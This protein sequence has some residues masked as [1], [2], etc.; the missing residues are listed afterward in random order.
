MTSFLDTLRRPTWLLPEAAHQASPL[1]SPDA[2][3]EVHL[4]G[5]DTI[6]RGSVDI[7]AYFSE[8]L[9]TGA[10]V[11]T[12]SA[13][14]S[15]G[16]IEL[17]IEVK[18]KDDLTLRERHLVHVR[19][20]RI[21]MHVVYPERVPFQVGDVALGAT[22]GV[23]ESAIERVP[24][25]SGFSGAPLEKVLLRD[26]RALIVKHIA[27]RWSWVMRATNDDGREASIWTQGRR[28]A[29]NIETAIVESVRLRDR[30]LLYMD[31]VTDP[32]SK[33]AAMSLSEEVVLLQRIASAFGEPSSA[34]QLCSLNDRLSLFSPATAKKEFDGTD[35]GPKIIGRGWQL[36]RDLI[37]T[38][39]FHIAHGLASTPGPLAQA[40]ATSPSALLHGDL[41]PGNFGVKGDRVVII[42]WGLAMW[43]PPALDVIW[44]LFN[45]RWASSLER[46]LAVAREVLRKPLDETAFD[47][48]IVATFIQVC[49]YFGFNVVHEPNP[50]ARVKA[51]KDLT[52][53][54]AAVERSLDRTSHLLSL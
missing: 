17:R 48:S 28:A 4:A 46:G 38:D 34:A 15:P 32:V 20:N 16:G 44:Y 8:R 11:N 37:P 42:D 43:G 30:W 1:Y 53:W 35:L 19:D 36:I 51:A 2:V 41:R 10:R 14:D 33:V 50:A 31:D 45:R 13:R 3:L 27:Q 5:I 24:L 6:V 29:P 9:P 49:P 26:G 25:T 7:A 21:E 22:T 39:L 40:L 12:L 23:V 54:V 52:S 47:L 18:T